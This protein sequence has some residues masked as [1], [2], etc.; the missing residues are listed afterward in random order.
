MIL[1]HPLNT[2][3]EANKKVI[4]KYSKR[5][6]YVFH[7]QFNM[8]MQI[9]DIGIHWGEK[10]TRHELTLKEALKL[11]KYYHKESKIEYHF[12]SSQILGEQ[13]IDIQDFNQDEDIFNCPNYISFDVVT[14]NNVHQVNF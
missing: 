13:K 8:W 5:K 1:K 14:P 6:V 12:V 9:P 3:D 11:T 7:G 4:K 10:N 2:K